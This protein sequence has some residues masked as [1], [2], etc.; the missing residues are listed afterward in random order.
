[1]AKYITRMDYENVCGWSVRWSSSGIWENDTTSKLFSDSKYGGKRRAL[2]A[3]KKFRDEKY[4][5]LKKEELLNNK[6]K[7]IVRRHSRNTSGIIGV[8]N[9]YTI[10]GNYI[11]EEW[12]A[13]GYKDGKHWRKAYSI[14]KYGDKGA[15]ILACRARHRKQ[16]TLQI[17]VR[18]KDLPYRPNV[19][20]NLRRKNEK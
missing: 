6:L 2:N 8:R 9:S 17:V 4:K 5:S 18:L 14:N 1:M 7:R 13:F 16:G 12:T 19:P 15:F 11:Y 20:Y 3:A 10:R